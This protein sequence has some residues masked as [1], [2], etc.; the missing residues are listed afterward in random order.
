MHII[1]QEARAQV[2]RSSFTSAISSMFR[3]KKTSSAS[4]SLTGSPSLQSLQQSSHNQSGLTASPSASLDVSMAESVLSSSLMSPSGPSSSPYS[5]LSREVRQHAMAAVL[6]EEWLQELAAV[7]QEHGVLQKE[8]CFEIGMG[9]NLNGGNVLSVA[10][11]KSNRK[12][13][14]STCANA[15]DIST[16]TPKAAAK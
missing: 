14:S 9:L 3:G 13:M 5:H 11:S 6:L 4:T 7:A 15:K 12:K 16:S 2:Q 10:A 8:Q 1:G